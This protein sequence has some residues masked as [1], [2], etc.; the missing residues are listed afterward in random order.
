M[1]AK[2]VAPFAMPRSSNPSR[3]AGI[4]RPCCGA[5]SSPIC[6]IRIFRFSDP[7]DPG[8]THVFRKEEGQIR[9]ETRVQSEVRRA[10]IQYAFG[11]R[12]HY[13]SLVGPDDRGTPYI[14]RLSHYQSDRESGW[15]RTTGHSADAGGGHDFLGKPLDI[16]DGIHKCLFCHSTNPIAILEKSGPELG[17]PRDRL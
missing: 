13:T 7:D 10:V 8:V 15:V 6:L 9:F 16:L 14:L 1:L 4:P 5:A 11:S 3:R 2:L 17:R 12:D